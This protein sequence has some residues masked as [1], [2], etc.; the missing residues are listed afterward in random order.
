MPIKIEKRIDKLR[1]NFLWQGNK[2]IKLFNLVNW[3]SVIKD[4]K[5]GGLGIRNLRQQNKILLIKWSWRFN[6]EV[7]VLWVDVIRNK[8]GTDGQWY[9]REVRK[10]YVC[11]YGRALDLCGLALRLVLESRWTMEEKFLC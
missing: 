1:N 9:T 4:R 3:M 2:E 10:S 8:Y 6:T 11:R 5:D 7:E